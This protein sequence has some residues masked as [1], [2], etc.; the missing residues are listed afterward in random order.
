MCSC[1][2]DR[3]RRHNAARNYAAR[4]ASR[5]GL[6]PEVEKA[7][8]LQPSPEHPNQAERRPA[9]VFLPAWLSGAPV[10]LDFAV[11]SPQ[12][13]EVL[14]QASLQVG[15]ASTLYDNFKRKYLDTEADCKRQGVTFQPMVAEPS[16]GWSPAAVLVWK[17]LARMES[18]RTGETAAQIAERHFQ[19][20]SVTIRGACA[21]AVIRR[22]EGRPHT[23]V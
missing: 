8:L 7:G 9:D 20:L 18:L 11:V 4:A 2:G 19:R 12:R 13:Q 16:G 1:A 5:A 23:A 17:Q 3:V 21:D 14:R 10:A 6:N 22:A 15:Y